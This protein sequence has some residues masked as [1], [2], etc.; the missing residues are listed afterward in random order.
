MHTIWRVCVYSKPTPARMGR[1]AMARM[2]RGAMIL[3]H[4]WAAVMSHLDSGVNTQTTA[5]ES[6]CERCLECFFSS[7]VAILN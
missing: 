3:K 5:R 2:G 7:S 4:C 1:G 6:K